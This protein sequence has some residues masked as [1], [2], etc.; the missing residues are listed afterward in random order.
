MTAPKLNQL[1]RFLLVCI[2]FICAG[3]AT[4]DDEY[5]K[6]IYVRVG[7]P[8][9]AFELKDDQGAVWNLARHCAK[10]PVVIYF[11]SG[12][13]MKSCTTQAR[14]YSADL[15]KIEAQGAEV[16]GVSGDAVVNHQLFKEKYHL[17]QTLLSDNKGA[18][19]TAFG[20]A[21]SGGGQWPVKDDKGHETQLTR[22]AT[23]S[24]WT[25]IIGTDGRVIYKDVNANPEGDSKKVLKFLTEWNAKQQQ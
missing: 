2:L 25:W 6:I 23:E 14:I 9:P 17:K 15:G 21:M 22:G 20:L 18:V 4:A 16:V 12:D 5:Q 1:A 13:F 7:D 11:Y 10:K 3:T 19:G 8:A 24:R